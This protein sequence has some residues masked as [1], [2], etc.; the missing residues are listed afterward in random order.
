MHD[1]FP[2]Y[3]RRSHANSALFPWMLPL[4]A[5]RLPYW[6]LLR[7]VVIFHVNTLA[8]T[9]AE[10]ILWVIWNQT[11]QTRISLQ[12]FLDISFFICPNYLGLPRQSQ[13]WSRDK[14]APL[15]LYL[16]LW[17]KESV[18]TIRWSLLYATK[19]AFFSIKHNWQNYSNNIFSKT[20][21]DTQF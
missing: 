2:S 11:S 15:C 6:G 17:L 18:N 4:G 1:D 21:L 19:S 5:L 8:N 12:V 7:H 20:H 16:N 9:P 10:L 13:I 3:I 14:L